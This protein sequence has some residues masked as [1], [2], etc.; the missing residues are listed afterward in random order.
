MRIFYT[1]FKI[2]I[3]EENNKNRILSLISSLEKIMTFYC[4]WMSRIDQIVV[5]TNKDLKF[6][7]LP[8]I[9]II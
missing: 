9:K 3:K 7:K 4:F 6:K 2:L 8:R 5:Y 1:M